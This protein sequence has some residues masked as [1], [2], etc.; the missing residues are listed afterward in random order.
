MRF[1]QSERGMTTDRLTAAVFKLSIDP[2]STDSSEIFIDVAASGGI[3]GIAFETLPR[4]SNGMIVLPVSPGE[5]SVS[6]EVFP[7]EEGIGYNTLIVDF[8]IIST[9]E[10]LIADGLEGVFSSLIILNLK[11]PV[12]TLPFSENFDA[13]D[14]ESG[15][16]SLPF[17]WEEIIVKQNSLGTGRW[18]CSS[19]LFGVECNAYSED[20]F[21][22]D[23]CEVWLISPPVSLAG[24][25]IR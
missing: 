24:N 6:F 20:G 25:W 10:G 11:D 2:P 5:E 7:R 4:L 16:G 21:N 23:D 13:C 9:G 22:G 3:P 12:R 8:E 14:L 19:S 15:D 17:G 18:E 1:L